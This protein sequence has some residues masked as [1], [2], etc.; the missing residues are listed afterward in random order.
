MAKP[1]QMWQHYHHLTGKLATRTSDLRR[2]R[3]NSAFMRSPLASRR[4][5]E[6][7]GPNRPARRPVRPR[8]RL[9]VGIRDPI[10]S[11]SGD[12]KGRLALAPPPSLSLSLPLPPRLRAGF[13]GIDL[14]G[15]RHVS[16]S[17]TTSPPCGGRG[18]R[19]GVQPA[20]YPRRPPLAW[21]LEILEGCLRAISGF[22]DAAS[23]RWSVTVPDA[24]GDAP[25]L[26]VRW[27]GVD[28]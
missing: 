27:G 9:D 12:Q 15:R 4:R 19:T 11:C 22:L 8:L 17:L 16:G 1:P 14:K 18:V 6:H 23:A 5:P 21:K 2:V 13:V 28:L 26:T 7:P 25:A 10:Q 24:P 20:F 3:D